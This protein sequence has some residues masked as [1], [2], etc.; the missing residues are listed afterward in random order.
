MSGVS[1]RGRSAFAGDASGW[2]GEVLSDVAAAMRNPRPTPRDV[3][4]T[5]SL[6][7]LILTLVALAALILGEEV[8]RWLMR[9]PASTAKVHPATGAVSSLG[10]FL[11][12]GTAVILLF[13]VVALRGAGPVP[14]LAFLKAGA[15]VSFYL[16]V[17][18]FFLLHESIAPSIGIRERYAVLALAAAV[19]AYLLL[20][21]RMILRHQWAWMLA[22]LV[23]L[24]ASVI[25]DKLFSRPGEYQVGLLYFIEDGLKLLAITCW[26]RFH[27]G[28]VLS[29]IRSGLGAPGLLPAEGLQERHPEADTLLRPPAA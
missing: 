5:L 3:V 13:G 7:V 4:L 28:V 27:A 9:D 2:H 18:D 12:F 15:A 29:T 25:S 24:T 8:V 16:W 26:A 23:L 14:E 10:A 19:G 22:A 21:W 11:W 6:P 1:K 17:D 20:F